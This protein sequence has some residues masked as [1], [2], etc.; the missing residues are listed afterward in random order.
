MSLF[1][2]ELVVNVTECYIIHACD[3]CGLRPPRG[4]CYPE[5]GVTECKC[6]RIANDTGTLEYTDRCVPKPPAPIITT[7]P[8]SNSNWT[9]VI[10][11]VLAGLAALFCATTCCLWAV[12]AWRRRI[13]NPAK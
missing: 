5:Y 7:S 4:I 10:V 3:L 9:P 11:G 12:A 6:F 2:V 1:Y 13:R 8:P